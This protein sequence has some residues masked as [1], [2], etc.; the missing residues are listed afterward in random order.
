MTQKKQIWKILTKLL[1]MKILQKIKLWKITRI[2]GKKELVHMKKSPEI[3]E[4]YLIK[5]YESVIYRGDLAKILN[6][7]KTKQDYVKR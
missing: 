1:G 7:L 2:R 5:V 3:I 4:A 6:S